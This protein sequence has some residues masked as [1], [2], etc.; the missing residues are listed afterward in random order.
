MS[1][2]L[3]T[4]TIEQVLAVTGRYLTVD[5]YFTRREE[6][7]LRG[8]LSGG[9]TDWQRQLSSELMT[10]GFALRVHQNDTV[11]HLNIYPAAGK[12][13]WL[14]VLLFAATLVSVSFIPASIAERG[15]LFVL[16]FGL[17]VKWLPF[18]IPLLLILLCHEFGHYFAARR[19][20]IRV[21]LPYFL[22]APNIIGTFGALI[23]S[24]SP[25]PNR[26]DLLEVGALGPIAGFAV[27]LVF[28][29][30][31]LSD[32]TYR[33]S[34]PATEATTLIE[35]LVMRAV[36]FLVQAEP[37]PKGYDIFL[38]DNLMLFA[39][40]VGMVVTM[41]NL[42]PVGQLDGGHIA[43]ALFP[44]R[45][46]RISWAIFFLLLAMGFVWIGWWLF[47]ALLY[48]VMRFRHPPTLNDQRPLETKSKLLGWLAILV[49]ILTFTP[50]PF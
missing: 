13:P 14:N 4:E 47:A 37:I 27:A 28:L 34:L 29:A 46:K 23:K 32:I 35:P 36:L 7:N 9:E 41:I 3:T 21:S 2:E 17:M 43:Y 33:A 40:W 19:R 49:F 1:R 38:Q 50:I 24:K 18:S 12:I 26:R 10:L 5:G 39:A 42:L 30:L 22:P 8:S 15:K 44:Q 6:I 45:H 11:V 48:I 16:D 25:F 20:G 31:A